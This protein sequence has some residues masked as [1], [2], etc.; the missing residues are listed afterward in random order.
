MNI[1]TAEEAKRIS[2]SITTKEA[3]GQ[4]TKIAAAIRA[5]VKRGRSS[6]TINIYIKDSVEKELT[7]LGYRVQ[8]YGNQNNGDY[9]QV[10]W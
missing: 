4:L 6:A 7:N 5:A 1:M 9:I 3:Q 10:S 8:K 2:S